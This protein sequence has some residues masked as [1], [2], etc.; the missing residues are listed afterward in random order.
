MREKKSQLFSLKRHGAV[1]STL[2][3]LFTFCCYCY[4]LQKCLS[5]VLHIYLVCSSVRE[6]QGTHICVRFFFFSLLAE[7]VRLLLF[8]EAHGGRDWFFVLVASFSNFNG[9]AHTHT[10]NTNRFSRVTY[11]KNLFFFLCSG[12]VGVSF[13][14]YYYLI[15]HVFFCYPKTITKQLFCG[16]SVHAVLEFSTSACAKGKTHTYIGIL[17]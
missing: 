11:V 13:F 7:L 14:F 10:H 17:S 5:L 8:V 16:R 4:L 9:H 12:C 2:F 1:L 3:S 6:M 15:W